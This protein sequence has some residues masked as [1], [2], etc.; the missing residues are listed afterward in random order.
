MDGM[1][2][3][4]TTGQ[5]LAVKAGVLSGGVTYKFRLESW[6]SRGGARGYSE[7]AKEVNKA[8]YDGSCEVQPTR[9]YLFQKAF[10]IKCH[11]WQDDT[12]LTYSVTAQVD[13]D[14][15]ETLIPADAVLDAGKDYVTQLLELPVGKKEKDFWIDVFVKIKDE[16]GASHKY[17]LK[18]QVRTKKLFNVELSRGTTS[19]GNLLSETGL[20]LTLI[21]KN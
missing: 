1:L 13:G 16:D 6:D 20:W 7:Y 4:S 2:T 21:T 9:G 15:P 19:G 5:T 8:P 17:P 3:T 14:Q 18:A 12:K 11:G 10:E